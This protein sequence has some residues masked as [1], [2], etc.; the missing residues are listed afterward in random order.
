VSQ[1]TPCIK[2]DLRVLDQQLE[3][4]IQKQ[5]K[6]ID[7]KIRAFTREQYQI[8]EEFRDRLYNEHIFLTRYLLFNI[9]V[10]YKNILI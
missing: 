5:I 8:L 3:K 6:L 7:K 9:H 2:L 4:G 10:D 1:L